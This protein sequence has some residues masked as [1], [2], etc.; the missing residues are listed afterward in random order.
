MNPRNSSNQPAASNPLAVME[1]GEQ[2]I[3][4]IKRH[5]IGIYGVYVAVGLGLFVLALAV[6]II[7]PSVFSN[8][9][10]SRIMLAGAVV[11]LVAAM[12]GAGFLLVASKVYWGNRWIL[13]SDSITQVTRTSLFDK[14]TSQLSLGDLE[15]IT[16]EQNGV[17]AE[18]LHYGV[19]S[20][21]TAAATD[22]FTFLYCP[23]PTYY[24][25]QIL[26]AR[27][28]F[29]QGKTRQ[30][31]QQ[32]SSANTGQAT[33]GSPINPATIPSVGQ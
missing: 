6:F 14:Q 13:T 17:L 11:F 30:D 2:V 4:E 7:A 25:R 19:I 22:K 21:E 18:M 28:R 33:T 29:E 26:G 10:Q 1:P 24:A 9:S 12:A 32:P 31:G 20:A 23:N 16:A 27:E 3:C 5:P 15:D 8:Y